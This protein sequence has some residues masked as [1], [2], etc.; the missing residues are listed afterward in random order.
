MITRKRI[1]KWLK[2]IF[3]KPVWSINE[4]RRL[5]YLRKSSLWF[6]ENFKKNTFNSKAISP[7]TDDLKRIWDSVIISKPK[8]LV[9]Y[10]SGYSTLIIKKA[11]DFNY[12]KYQ[13]KSRFF[14]IENIKP[15]S[16]NTKKL[17]KKYQC[18]SGV[19][20]LNIEPK[21]KLTN[22]N[23]N[24]E[25]QPIWYS[26]KVNLTEIN[27]YL[28]FYEEIIK[29]LI[30]DFFYIDGPDPKS[31]KLPK[32]IAGMKFTSIVGDILYLETKLKKGT[33]VLIDGRDT[34]AF[35]LWNNFKRKWIKKTFPNQTTTF[36]KLIE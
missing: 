3:L 8:L 10:G 2:N 35:I 20:I 1:I 24:R 4:L 15:W 30:P 34:N 19:N 27:L 28:V 22:L 36:F 5:I 21:I 14:S 26:A 11:L 31:I 29:K 13:L 6:S 25:N 17:L 16:D 18:D 12:Q 23:L 33:V 32:N 9:E 7:Q